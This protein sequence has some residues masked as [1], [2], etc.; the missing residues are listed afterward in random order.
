MRCASVVRVSFGSLRANSAILRCRVEMTSRPKV[1]VICPSASSIIRPAA[2]LRRVPW[3]EFPDLTGTISRLRLLAPH[4]ASLR[5]L[6]SA[7]PPLRPLRSSGSGASP[8][9][10]ATSIAAP[11]PPHHGG[12]DE[13]SQVP[14]RP[15]CTCPALRPRRTAEPQ[16]HTGPAIWS[17]VQLTT[18]TP[19]LVLS[20]LYHAACTLSVYASQ[21]GSPPGHATL[22]SGWWPTFTGQDSHLL[23]RME[24]FRHVY[25]STWL[26]PS[27]GFA[28]RKPG[29][30]RVVTH[31]RLP[32]IRACPTRA[33]GSSNDGLAAQRYTLC[34]TRA[35]GRG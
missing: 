15:L 6:R 14:G 20:R 19:R 27:P 25:P 13:T 11:A 8:G 29:W 7:L 12:E 33:P 28:W 23:G 30:P 10:R 21:P 24:G 16:A 22:D 31:P 26:P 18:S 32:Q 1:P 9:A 4:R 17:S 3:G 35:V 2:S 34:T 5:L